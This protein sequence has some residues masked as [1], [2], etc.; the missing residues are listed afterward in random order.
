MR[1]WQE[2]FSSQ[3]AGTVPLLPDQK[4]HYSVKMMIL[5]QIYTRGLFEKKSLRHNSLFE[6]L[7]D[8]TNKMTERPAKTD[9]PGHSPQSDQSSLSA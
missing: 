7:H 4:F 1:K 6:P 3:S 8:K 5:G 2:L 9:Q